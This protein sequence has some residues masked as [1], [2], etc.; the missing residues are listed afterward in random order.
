MAR[1]LGTTSFAGSTPRRAEHLTPSGQAVRAVDCRLED[2]A[3]DS[4]REPGLVRTLDAD[5]KSVYQAFNCCWLQ[6]TKCASWA[7]GSVEQRHVFA[8][9]YNDFA[10][11][12]RIV[13]DADCEETVLR[14]GLPCPTEPPST[15]GTTTFSKASSPRQ[16]VYR[17]VDSLG[18]T[19]N[20][21]LPSTVLVT[22]D[23][24]AVVVSGWVLPPAAENWDIQEIQILRSVAGYESS[25]KEGENKID[26][27][28]MIVDT[29]PAAQTSFVD[30]AFDADLLEAMAEDEAAPPP[31]GLQGMTW[32]RSMNCLAGFAGRKLYFSENNNYHNWPYQL[33]LDDTVKAIVE[34][35]GQIYVATDGAPYV[36]DGAADCQNA[37]CRQAI[38][39]PEPLPLVGSGFRNMV[40]LPS[41]AA[42]PSHS[43]MVYLRS[44]QV[45]QMLTSR[46]YAPSDWQALHPDTMKAVYHEGRLYAF[47]RKGAF[48]LALQEGS[49]TAGE[50]EHHTE[51]S[52]RP[53]EVLQTRLGRLYLRFGREIK[54]WD[55]GTRRM[56]HLWE[57]GEVL[58]GVPFNFGALQ[59]MMEPGAE[60]VSLTVDGELALDEE[61]FASDHFALPLWATG[62]R[63][64]WVLTGTARVKQISLAPSTKEL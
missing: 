29:I 9:G 30:R 34:S 12:V 62:Q 41:G 54:E 32:V 40:A 13:L 26:A 5:A 46:H 57:S 44:R 39:M 45:P 10:Y 58:A 53:D 50:T 3:L 20:T 28:W 55:R 1:T 22:E 14:L 25:F 59:V 8:T 36:V 47:F 16:Y 35:N 2:G 23:G 49:S 15:Q 37:G 4:W 11:P 60:R 43:G 31:A 61:L 48:C 7:E 63:F 56:P 42:Y 24:D 18:N 64:Q 19:S 27:A 52:L 38:R 33:Q 17:W 21:S 6:S 51:L